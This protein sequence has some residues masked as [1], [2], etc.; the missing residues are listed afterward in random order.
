MASETPVQPDLAKWRAWKK[1]NSH[2]PLSVAANG[3][4]K[5]KILGH[6]HYFGVLDDTKTALKLWLQEKDYLLAGESPPTPEEASGYTLS[7][8][9]D[10]HYLACEARVANGSMSTWSLKD[11]RVIR[12]FFQA[13]GVDAILTSRLT[14][15]HWASVLHEIETSNLRPRS[16]HNVI[17]AIKTVVNWGV[18]MELCKPARYGPRF[19]GPGLPRIEADQEAN[20]STRFFDRELL[21]A[22]IDAAKPTMKVVVLLGLNCG[23]YVQDTTAIT[24]EH[25][26]LDHEIPHH[27]FRRVKTHRR[28]MATLWPATVTAIREYLESQLSREPGQRR[29]MLTKRGHPYLSPSASRTLPRAF[30]ELIESV[31]DRPA[32]ASLGSLRHTYATVAGLSSDQPMIDLAMGHVAGTIEGSR[33]K[34]LQRRIY[35]QLNLGELD[36]LAAVA[37]VVRR[38]LYYGE[39]TGVART[40]TLMQSRNS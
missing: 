31:G 4:W 32:G 37:E 21:L 19:A 24:I 33:K 7:Q 11:F 38:W 15:S 8:L 34:S 12:R 6:T 30:D 14:P 20:G 28:R 22:A 9:C 25:L 18:R 23:F 16:Q 40:E 17:L 2:Y 29:L 5:R 35:S 10:K 3:Q 13:A 1:R 26:H 27:D 39:I 36:R